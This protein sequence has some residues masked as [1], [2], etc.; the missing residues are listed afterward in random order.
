[1]ASL[2]FV[3]HHHGKGRVRVAKRIVDQS[4]QN[5]FIEFQ[6]EVPSAPPSKSPLNYNIH[7][8]TVSGVDVEPRM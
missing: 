4:G 7:A 6:C 8:L 5:H 2:N 3:D 1:M